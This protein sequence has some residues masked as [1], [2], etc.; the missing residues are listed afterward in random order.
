[1]SILGG[2]LSF[3]VSNVIM[4]NLLSIPSIYSEYRIYQNLQ[5]LDRLDKTNYL[6]RRIKIYF[7]NLSSVFLHISY[8]FEI[9]II[10]QDYLLILDLSKRV[11]R[12][13]PPTEVVMN[14]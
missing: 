7:A 3:H 13:A 11:V 9:V 8:R 5:H 1:M 14:G 12:T 6:G 2:T 10:L 4:A